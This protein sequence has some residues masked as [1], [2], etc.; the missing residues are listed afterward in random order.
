MIR[1]KTSL[2]IF[3][4]LFSL[5][6]CSPS[7]A[8]PI[9]SAPTATFTPY[10]GGTETALATQQ[11][12]PTPWIAGTET[13]LANLTPTPWVAGTETAVAVANVSPT[14]SALPTL[15][16]PTAITPTP[17]VS[18]SPVFLAFK[19]SHSIILLGGINETRG[20]LPAEDAFAY[21]SPAVNYDFFGPNLTAHVAGR[22]LE[23]SPTCRNYFLGSSDIMPDAMVGVASNWIVE[24]RATQDLSTDDPAY[25]QALGEWFQSR[26]SSPD[27]IRITRVLQADMEGDGVNEVL[28]S[29]SSFKDPSGHMTETGDYSVVLM[30]K[31]VGNDVVTVPLISEYYVASGPELSYPNTYTLMEAI[32]L[33]QDGTLEVVVEVHR[34]EGGGGIVYRVDGQNVREVMRAVC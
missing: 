12:S 4:L 11:A 24:K 15:P 30:R 22:P 1:V 31:V 13:A 16:P 20:W 23:F 27:E 33:N 19:D 28:L 17:D 3:V 18:F 25:V 34:W 29:A 21:V 9:A 26:G 10:V 2:L 5:I 32:D 8:L 14:P 6:A 7:P